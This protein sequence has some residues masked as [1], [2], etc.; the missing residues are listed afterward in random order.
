LGEV[1]HNIGDIVVEALGG[2]YGAVME[3]RYFEVF[4]SEDGVSF[5]PAGKLACADEG[6][7]S[8]YIKRLTLELDESA[9]ARFVKI[10][11]S[12]IGWFF[13]DEIEIIAYE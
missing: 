1:T 7:G 5:D 12:C 11:V 6:T 13:T 4:V 8:L 9:S 3:P 2:G 10:S